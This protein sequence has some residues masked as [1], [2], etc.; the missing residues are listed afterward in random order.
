MFKGKVAHVAN[1]WRIIIDMDE[2]TNTVRKRNMSLIGVNNRVIAFRSVR[3][4]KVDE[5]MVGADVHIKVVGGTASAYYL[6]FIERR[7]PK[8]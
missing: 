6:S 3:S 5:R 7:R 2:K 1:F 8:N 4:V